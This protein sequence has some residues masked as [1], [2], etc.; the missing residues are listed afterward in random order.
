MKTFTEVTV[1][2]GYEEFMVHLVEGEPVRLYVYARMFTGHDAGYTPGE[3]TAESAA[4]NPDNYK[5]GTN[6]LFI[7]CR[8]LY[9]VRRI[10]SGYLEEFYDPETN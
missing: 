9:L 1:S 8:S 5:P 2:D 10:W 7:H 3:R 4:Y 6:P